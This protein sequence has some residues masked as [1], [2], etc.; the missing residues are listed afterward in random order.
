MSEHRAHVAVA[1]AGG[2]KCGAAR[3]RQPPADVREE[4]R[5]L[6]TELDE[7]VPVKALDRNLLI[8]TWN[9]R[10]FGD[11]TKKWRGCRSVSDLL[12]W[13]NPAEGMAALLRLLDP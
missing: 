2:W 4:L 10:A 12:R 3:T 13:P 9:I 11:A 1:P 8:G 7:I 6:H 5:L